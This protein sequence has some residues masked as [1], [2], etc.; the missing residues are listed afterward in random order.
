VA[1]SKF[2]LV[3]ALAERIAQACLAEPGVQKVRVCL[4]KPGALRATRTV[5]VEVVRSK[6]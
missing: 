5:G 4:E 3:E 1:E 2:F 6:D